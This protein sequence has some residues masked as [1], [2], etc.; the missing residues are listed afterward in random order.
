MDKCGQVR[1]VAFAGKPEPSSRSVGF[2][3]E[4]HAGLA[5]DS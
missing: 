4:R 2:S 1:H 5:R 3:D